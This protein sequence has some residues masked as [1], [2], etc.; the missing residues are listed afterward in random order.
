MTA[1]FY[2]RAWTSR[3]KRYP[4]AFDVVAVKHDQLAIG[5]GRNVFKVVGKFGVCG[6][7]NASR[8]SRSPF[9]C[10]VEPEPGYTRRGPS[11]VNLFNDPP[12]LLLG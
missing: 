5:R 1:K 7:V 2:D 11:S 4:G 6:K 10:S 3:L 9:H 8:G 12:N